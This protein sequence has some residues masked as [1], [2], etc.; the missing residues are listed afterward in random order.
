MKVLSSTAFHASVTSASFWPSASRFA[1]RSI[2]AMQ[3]AER[4]GCAVMELQAVA[5]REG[6][7]ELVVAELALVDHLRLDLE[8]RVD[9]E[10]RVVDHVAVVAG[11]VGRGRD[12]IEDAQIRLRHELERLLLR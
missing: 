11:D 10:Q 5:Q 4:T 7:G 6:V 9:R 3:S 2:E 12:R 8:L 1:Q